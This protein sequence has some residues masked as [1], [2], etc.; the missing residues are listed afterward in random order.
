MFTDSLTY[1]YNTQPH[2]S[3]GIY[4]FELVLAR[5]PPVLAMENNPAMG[6]AK[7]PRQYSTYVG[8]DACKP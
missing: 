7:K 3:T 5:P 8:K 1:A 2:S 4:P 6:E